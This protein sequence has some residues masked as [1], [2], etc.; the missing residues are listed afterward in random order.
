[1]AGAVISGYKFTD[2]ILTTGVN[3]SPQ[4]KGYGFDLLVVY[5]VWIGLVII[6]YPLCKAYERYKRMH[7]SEYRWL[8]Y[9]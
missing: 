7:L 9:L 4:L 2:M 5:L 1:M 6:L 8:S 3:N